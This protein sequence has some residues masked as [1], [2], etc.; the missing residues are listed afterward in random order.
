MTGVPGIP[1]EHFPLSFLD[2]VASEIL[3]RVPGI[4]RVVYDLTT[5]PPATV[6]LVE[7]PCLIPF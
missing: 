1:G 7:L 6:I 3:S 2:D 4:V 5:K